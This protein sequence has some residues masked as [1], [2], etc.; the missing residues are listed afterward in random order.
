MALPLR[1]L[2]VRTAAAIALAGVALPLTGGQAEPAPVAA[3]GI[4]P[5]RAVYRM[6]LHSARNS[7][8]IADVR[9]A[10][11]Y[12]QSDA[13][14]GWTTEQRF[15]LRFTYAEGEEMNMTTHYLSDLLRKTVGQNTQQLIHSL[16][17]D[18][19]KNLLKS[20][21]L[22]ANEIAYRLGFDSPQYFSRLFKQKAGMTP[23]QLRNTG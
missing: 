12:E 11:M 7:S 1:R 18:K 14:D 3:T 5:H 21:S 4:T 8:K 22:S 23:L 13:C 15:Q 9:G 19:A 16:L 2:V 10:M 6:A 17:I 20:T